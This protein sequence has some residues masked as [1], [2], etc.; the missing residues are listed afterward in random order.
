MAGTSLVENYLN[1]PDTAIQLPEYTVTANRTNTTAAKGSGFLSILGTAI[2]AGPDYIK[3]FKGAQ[4]QQQQNQNFLDFLK[5]QNSGGTQQAG[6]GGNI[7][8]IVVLVGLGL[9]LVS[10]FAKGF[11]TK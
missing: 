1:T 2:T 4:D 9:G 3:A 7:I 5:M 10:L 6:I 11:K 8:L